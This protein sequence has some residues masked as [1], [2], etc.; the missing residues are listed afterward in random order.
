MRARELIFEAY[1]DPAK[2]EQSKAKLT[3]TRRPRLTLKHLNTLRRIKEIR[4]LELLGKKET[5]SQIYAAPAAEGGM[6]P[7]M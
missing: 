2:D 1:Y 5:L 7:G 4:K 6:P 3:D